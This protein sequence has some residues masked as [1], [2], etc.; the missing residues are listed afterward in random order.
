MKHQGICGVAS[1]AV[2]NKADA[3]IGSHRFAPAL[4][5]WPWNNKP[6]Q[7]QQREEPSA[8]DCVFS[9][10]SSVVNMSQPQQRSKFMGAPDDRRTTQVKHGHHRYAHRSPRRRPM[11][12]FDRELRYSS[13]A[14]RPRLTRT[15]CR[16]SA[17][18]SRIVLAR[19]V[20]VLIGNDHQR[21]RGWCRRRSTSPPTAR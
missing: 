9:W 19:S 10:A 11:R 16:P 4:C 21:R 7:Q 18:E 6:Q 13:A 20:A 14:L 8:E 3:L 17:A 15:P 1:E 5:L 2:T 12:L